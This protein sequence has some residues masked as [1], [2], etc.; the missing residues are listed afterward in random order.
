MR[1]VLIIVSTIAF[2]AVFNAVGAEPPATQSTS[3]AVSD[4]GKAPS[5]DSGL[6]GSAAKAD[7][8]HQA[9]TVV[10]APNAQDSAKLSRPRDTSRSAIASADSLRHKGK[11]RDSLQ[12]SEPKKIKLQTRKFGGKHQVLLAVFMMVFVA[13]IVTMAQQWNPR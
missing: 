11:L 3:A 12:R 7:S 5:A 4:S 8:S 6:R 13:G 1:A 10:A 2:I 9:S